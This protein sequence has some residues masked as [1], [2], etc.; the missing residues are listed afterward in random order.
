MAGLLSHLRSAYWQ[1][2]DEA[3]EL[4]SFRVWL[5]TGRPHVNNIWQPAAHGQEGATLRPVVHLLISFLR[6]F[7]ESELNDIATDREGNLD[8]EG[9]IQGLRVPMVVWLPWM[10][11][12]KQC[13]SG[14]KDSDNYYEYALSMPW[15]GKCTGVYVYD[16][17]CPDLGAVDFGGRMAELVKK[18]G[19][20]GPQ[21]AFSKESGKGD[22]LLF[23]RHG[24]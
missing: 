1:W 3:A 19:G 12:I 22:I 24:T 2:K 5:A 11:I 23:G 15:A 18:E 9:R 10:A 20:G 17:R 6:G 14:R 8:P 21:M 13:A 7:A 16:V 4:Q